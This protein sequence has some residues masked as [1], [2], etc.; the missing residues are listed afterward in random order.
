[1]DDFASRL[2]RALEVRNLTAADLSRLTKITEGVISQYKSGKYVPKQK[3][4][5][6]L[7]QVLNVSIPWLMGY[8]VPMERSIPS[9]IETPTDE[10]EAEEEYLLAARSP[11][12]KQAIR[13]LTKQQYEIA[14]SVIESLEQNTDDNL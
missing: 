11:D 14:K 4:L 9:L 5:E 8:D 2:C 6:L 7:S 10:S 13:K 1:M 12:G 3:R